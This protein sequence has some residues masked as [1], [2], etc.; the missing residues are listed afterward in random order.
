MWELADRGN[1]AR[2]NQELSACSDV[3]SVTRKDVRVRLER[4]PPRLIRTPSL[5]TLPNA[6]SLVSH[7]ELVS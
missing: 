7:D 4:R 1:V 3:K 5:A 6:F 2:R